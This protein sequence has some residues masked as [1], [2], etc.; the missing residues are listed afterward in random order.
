[1]SGAKNEGSE[2]A[3]KGLDGV[4]VVWL[5]RVS[6]VENIFVATVND[7]VLISVSRRREPRGAAMARPLNTD[8][9]HMV[10][11]TTAYAGLCPAGRETRQR[12][13]LPYLHWKN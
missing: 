12:E 1:M 10:G 2:E 5:E 4:E 3:L 8:E 11:S 13:Y 9:T 6:E 7:K